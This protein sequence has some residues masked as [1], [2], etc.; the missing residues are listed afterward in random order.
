MFHPRVILPENLPIHFDTSLGMATEYYDSHATTVSKTQE[1]QG[2]S[3]G[4]LM[5]DP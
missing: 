3:L 1:T 2:S 5:V 4:N